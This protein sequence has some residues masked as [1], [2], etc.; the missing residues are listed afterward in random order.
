MQEF[1]D[2]FENQQYKGNQ[3]H[4]KHLTTEELISK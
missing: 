3:R 4:V 1:V 2:Q